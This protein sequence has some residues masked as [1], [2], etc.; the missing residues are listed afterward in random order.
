LAIA[1]AASL[2]LFLQYAPFGKFIRACISNPTGAQVVGLDV[3]R[4]SFVVFVVG[5]ACA[6]LAGALLMS[7]SVVEPYLGLDLTVIA[8]IISVMAGT[9]LWHTVYSGL[10]FGIIES[11]AGSLV[12]DSFSRVAV[13][14]IFILVMILKPQISSIRAFFWKRSTNSAGA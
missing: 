9:S 6:G 8:F 5:V 1:I 3:R 7:Y 2:H 14:S 13:F 11:I 12:S 4:V 10:A